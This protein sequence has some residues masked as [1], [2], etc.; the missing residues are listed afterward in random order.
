MYLVYTAYVHH[1]VSRSSWVF[2]PQNPK[3]PNIRIISQQLYLMSIS[4]GSNDG[5]VRYFQIYL[6]VTYGCILCMYIIYVY[7]II[8]KYIFTLA[9]YCGFKD[10]PLYHPVNV[11]SY[12]FECVI[13]GHNTFR[14][15]A[16]RILLLFRDDGPTVCLGCPPRECQARRWRGNQWPVGSSPRCLAAKESTPVW[17]YEKSKKRCFNKKWRNMS[18]TNVFQFSCN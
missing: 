5:S 16:A 6:W 15:K 2:H 10:F 3:D 9:N 11:W 12:H 7:H 17:P 4:F 18:N 8:S 14:S 13:T 1:R